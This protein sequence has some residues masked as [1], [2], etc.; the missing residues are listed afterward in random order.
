MVAVTEYRIHYRV[1]LMTEAAIMNLMWKQKVIPLLSPR[2]PLYRKKRG[3][4]DYQ[5]VGGDCSNNN[6]LH[7]HH[8]VKLAIHP[9]HSC[10]F[11]T[12]IYRILETKP[13]SD[14]K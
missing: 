14:L 12:Y 9:D 5:G 7:S 3:G 11:Y 13:L 8:R 10:T 6:C 4:C 2:F 1:V